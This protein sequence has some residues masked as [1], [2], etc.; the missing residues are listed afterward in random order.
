[1]KKLNC[2]LQK[3]IYCLKYFFILK[4]KNKTKVVKMIVVQIGS[5]KGYDDLTEILRNKNVEKLILVEPFEEHNFSLNE[6]YSHISNKFIENIIITDNSEKKL[7]YIFYHEEDTKHTNKFELASLNKLHSLKIRSNY[8]ETG[9]R[10]RELKALTANHLFEKYSLNKIDILFVDTE[11]F[12]DKIIRSIDF[13][14]FKIDT[15]YYENLHINSNDLRK[16]LELKN[17]NVIPNFGFGGWSDIA[18]LKK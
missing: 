15:I 12:D 11:G 17:Y 2:V 4:L 8:D 18:N 7:E 6:C 1:M 13:D 10:F 14:K 3:T 16:F 9:I 5:N